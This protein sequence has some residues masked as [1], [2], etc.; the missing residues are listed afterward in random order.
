MALFIGAEQGK[1]YKFSKLEEEIIAYWG[2]PDEEIG[3]P[4]YVSQ[5][6]RWIDSSPTHT[7]AMR[8]EN[9]NDPAT[10]T[11]SWVIIDTN[12]LPADRENVNIHYAVIDQNTFAHL[13]HNPRYLVVNARFARHAADGQAFY[14]FFNTSRIEERR[15]G[16]GGDPESS[17]A[18]VR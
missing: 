13:S 7:V 2:N 11:A 18:V 14:V 17:G 1:K 3:F 16:A 9:F 4:V 5:L 6:R 12:N 8:V 10:L 15:G